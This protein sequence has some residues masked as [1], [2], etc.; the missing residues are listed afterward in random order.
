[1]LVAPATLGALAGDAVG[2]VVSAGDEVGASG[3]SDVAGDL[4]ADGV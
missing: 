2:A 1:M 4:V 3:V